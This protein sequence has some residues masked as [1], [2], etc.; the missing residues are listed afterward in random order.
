MSNLLQVITT[1][2]PANHRHCLLCLRTSLTTTCN[3]TNRSAFWDRKISNDGEP[4]QRTHRGS[5][6]AELLDGKDYFFN[7]TV[8]VWYSLKVVTLFYILP[9]SQETMCA[10]CTEL[11]S[12]SRPAMTSWPASW[13]EQRWKNSMLS[14]SASGATSGSP[15][16]SLVS[17]SNRKQL[18]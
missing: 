4:P 16:W 13:S 2:L 7:K 14:S 18:A 5:Q 8:A 1:H 3:N 17:M 11:S 10:L 12:P 15:L 6:E 9:R